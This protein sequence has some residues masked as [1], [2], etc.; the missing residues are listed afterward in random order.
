MAHYKL[1]LINQE[2]NVN[3][4]F[5]DRVEYGGYAYGVITDE[6]DKLLGRHLSS[7]LS[8]LEHDLLN[9]VDF[10]ADTDTYEKNW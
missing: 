8:W 7:T 2:G 5:V 9:K 4:G 10:N 6:N 1:K 3:N